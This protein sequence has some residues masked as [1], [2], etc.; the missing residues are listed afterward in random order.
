MLSRYI[1]RSLFLLFY[2]LLP[3]IA[4]GQQLNISGTVRGEKGLPVPQ[5]TVSIDSLSLITSTNADGKFNLTIPSGFYSIQFS[6]SLYITKEL[7]VELDKQTATRWS[8][9]LS[10]CSGFE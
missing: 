6:H 2:L 3:L 8:N 10:R 7:A 4:R 1:Y 9:L 5:V